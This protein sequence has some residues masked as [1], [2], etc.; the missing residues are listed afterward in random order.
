MPWKPQ[1]PDDFP[2]L[3]WALLDWYA[4][5]LPSPRDPASPL[6]FPDG[7]AMTVVEWYRLDDQGRRVY[8]RGYSRR[9]KGYGKSPIEA[10]KSIG[11]FAGP[12]RFDGWDA[13]GQPVGR[14]WGRND[15]PRAWVQIGAISEDQTD[16]TWSVI[17]YFLTENDG[18]AADAL[19]ID[20]GLT[21]CFLR[22]QPGAKLE[23]VTSAAGSR[24]GQPITYGVI[25]ESHLMLPSNGGVK[26]ARTIRRNVAKMGGTSYETTNAYVVGQDSVAETSHKAVLAGGTG[27]FADEVEAPREIEGVEVGPDAPDGVLLA[28]LDVAY[29]DSW[30]V[31]KTRFVADARDPATPW[32]DIARFFMNWPTLDEDGRLVAAS[33]WAGMIDA[34]SK[35]ASNLAISLDVADDRKF[36]SFGA[37]GKRTDGRLHIE[38]LWREPGTGWVLG[39]G[40]QLWRAQKTPIRIRRGSPAESFVAPFREA[41]VE[42]IEFTRQDHAAA[43]G[44]FLDLANAD[45]LRHLDQTSINSA[46]KASQLQ[47]V[48]D[49]KVLGRRIS[50][51]DITALVSVIDALGG[52]P[53][54]S[55]ATD[56]F[57]AVT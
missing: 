40:L 55:P 33:L 50:R 3:G 5:F 25:D 46:L 38:N 20:A 18:R 4:E 17:H 10:A 27:I 43:V 29:G 49:V 28:A 16:N 42:V 13:N 26:L 23:P 24:E 19:R 31:D 48:G 47:P 51:G 7:H 32:E 8:R 54:T 57:L 1:H 15:D 34:E 9:S 41:G 52:V 22:D 11:E 12:V 35:I 44:R 14:P 56:L 36:S 45:Q 39:W 2:S 37:S 53:A 30:W 6:L 21:R